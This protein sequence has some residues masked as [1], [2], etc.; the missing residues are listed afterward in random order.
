MLGTIADI[1]RYDRPDD[2][3]FQHKAEIEAMTPAQVAEAAATIDP[4]ALTWV[5]VGDLDKIGAPVRALDLGAV[6]VLDADGNPVEAKAEAGAVASD[7]VSDDASA[8][9]AAN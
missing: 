1:V 7:A 8:D 9:D 5:V 6:Q 2:Y 3:V 4:S